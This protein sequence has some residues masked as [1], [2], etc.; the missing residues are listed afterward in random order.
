M[1]SLKKI[2][3]LIVFVVFHLG[4]Y[5]QCAMCKAVAESDLQSGGTAAMGINN[6][7]LYLM[8]IPY[9]LIGVVGFFI[10][11]H[12]KKNNIKSTV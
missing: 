9:L 1:I 10:Y 3:A 6:G 7:I 11:K 8:G 4:G 5:A 12:F 2:V